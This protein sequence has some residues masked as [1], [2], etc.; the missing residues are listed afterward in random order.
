MTQT[1][2]LVSNFLRLLQNE[3]P[4]LSDALPMLTL[5]QQHE[6]KYIGGVD[7]KT[8]INS[9]Y[10]VMLR[11][12]SFTVSDIGNVNDVVQDVKIELHGIPELGMKTMTCRCVKEAG[13]RMPRVDGVWGINVG[14]FK[15]V[16]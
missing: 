5:T 4:E 1:E 3:R 2:E 8:A 11:V 9:L 6:H 16:D 10:A 14:S 15:F 12:K 7:V 13:V